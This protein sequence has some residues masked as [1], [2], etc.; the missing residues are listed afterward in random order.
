MTERNLS[1]ANQTRDWYAR[2]PPGMSF[3]AGTPEEFELWRES[4]RGKLASLLGLDRL[5]EEEGRFVEAEKDE[6]FEADGYTAEKV[7]LRSQ[8]DMW[9]PSWVLVPKDKEPPYPA[10]LCLHGHAM[11]KDVMIGRPKSEEE[12][13]FLKQ[14]RGDYG[15]RFAEAGYLCFC[16]DARGFGER[17]EEHGCQQV[18]A[19][20][21]MVGR[22]LQ[23]LRVWDHLR[24][25]EYVASRKDVD[26]GRIGAVGFS[27]GCEHVMYLAVLDERIRACV[28][29]CCM[30]SL[31]EEIHDRVHCI[32]S[33]VPDLFRYF[34]W[35]D[36][37]CLIAPRA[38]LVQQGIRDQVPM[39]LV[40]A[41]VGKMRTAYALSGDA[42]K[43]GTDFF[44]GG[45]EF[46]FEAA[47]EWIDRWIGR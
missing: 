3:S 4:A 23:G 28:L 36:I 25:L 42:G 40:E 30:R 34:D 26:R 6:T 19:N 22:V 13:K 16:P 12:E 37:G 18:Y 29:S 39:K 33:Y 10:I 1:T 17:H 27:M 5:R 9:V 14:F 21:V 44:D 45:H 7:Y 47:L 35:S 8:E 31:R 15:R 41:A 11:S 43:V 46:R 32:C 38:A 24:G 20:A 2:H